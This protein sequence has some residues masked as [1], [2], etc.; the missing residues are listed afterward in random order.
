MKKVLVALAVARRGHPDRRL[1]ERPPERGGN[2]PSASWAHDQRRQRQQ[3]RR[4]RAG[5]TAGSRRWTALLLQGVTKKVNDI[6]GFEAD[7]LG[8]GYWIIGA[9]GAVYARGSTCQDETLVT[10]KNAPKSKVVGAI[11]LKSEGNE[12]FEMITASGR[13]FAFSCQF[14]NSGVAR[15][16]AV[17]SPLLLALGAV[18]DALA[19]VTPARYPKYL[20]N[21][22]LAQALEPRVRVLR[23]AIPRRGRLT[24]PVVGGG[25]GRRRG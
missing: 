7:G 10:P 15:L 24:D 16:P 11:N 1:G 8:G 4:L 6:V 12:G 17:H 25:R 23:R 22:E 21:D 14:T 18:E 2:Q 9:N 19:I 20:S 5:A 3:R 13:S